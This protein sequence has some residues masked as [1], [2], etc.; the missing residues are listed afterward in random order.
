M[1]TINKKIPAIQAQFICKKNKQKL[2]IDALLK[3]SQIN[4]EEIAQLIKVPVD[5]LL[6]VYQGQAFLNQ[7]RTLNLMY[8]FFFLFSD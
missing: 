8:L 3:C 7:K 1:K 6:D 5:T 2:L 4:I